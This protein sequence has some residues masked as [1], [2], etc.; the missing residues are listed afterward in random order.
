MPEEDF[1][2]QRPCL[3]P[4]NQQ[5]DSFNKKEVLEPYQKDY[6]TL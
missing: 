2:L 1:Q 4:Y 5:S 6:W 3:T